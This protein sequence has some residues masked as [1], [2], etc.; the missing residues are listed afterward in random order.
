M[1]DAMA[2]WLRTLVLL[3]FAGLPMAFVSKMLRG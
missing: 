1:V 2:S 3:V